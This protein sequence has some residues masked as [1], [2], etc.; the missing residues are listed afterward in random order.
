[1]NNKNTNTTA[2]LCVNKST[3][4]KNCKNINNNHNDSNSNNNN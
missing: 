1:M 3:N 4:I 2:N